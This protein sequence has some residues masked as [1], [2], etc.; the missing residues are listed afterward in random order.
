[1]VTFPTNY[2]E[3]LNK[4]FIKRGQEFTSASAVK[5]LEEAY[6]KWRSLPPQTQG[7]FNISWL[8]KNGNDDLYYWSSKNIPLTDLVALSTNEELKN[9][10]R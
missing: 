3:E 6:N 1:L 9:N 4:N 2:H 10:F 5:R 8:R 7:N